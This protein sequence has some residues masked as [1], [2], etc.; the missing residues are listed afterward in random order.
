MVGFLHTLH[1]FFPSQY[2]HDQTILFFRIDDAPTSA[3]EKTDENKFC[4]V[5][6]CDNGVVRKIIIPVDDNAY[7][8]FPSISEKNCK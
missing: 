8:V 6:V 4:N 1:F 2:F 5:E 3:D 7:P